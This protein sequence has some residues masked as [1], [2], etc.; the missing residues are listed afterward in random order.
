MKAI[1]L[2]FAAVAL[3]SAQ[4]P[5]LVLRMISVKGPDSARLVFEETQKAW[6]ERGVR[7]S[8]EDRM[9]PAALGSSVAEAA[10]AIEQRY[11]ELGRTVRVAYAVEPL[12]PRSVAVTFTVVEPVP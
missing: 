4:G 12:P 1:L 11:R 7:L 10:Q 5:A 8:A 2:G 6:T 9:T 3:L